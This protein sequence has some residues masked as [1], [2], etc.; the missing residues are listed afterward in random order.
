MR[1]DNGLHLSDK[2]F[3]S[4]IL[5]HCYHKYMYFWWRT[6]EMKYTDLVVQEWYTTLCNIKNNP[7]KLNV[8]RKFRYMWVC[9]PIY[10]KES[11]PLYDKFTIL[12]S[13]V[14]IFPKKYEANLISILCAYVL[15]IQ[16]ARNCFKRAT[17]IRFFCSFHTIEV[18]TNSSTFCH[19]TLLCSFILSRSTSAY[20]VI[21]LDA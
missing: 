8:I 4:H 20:K 6:L 3:R 19:G 12:F 17:N 9:I 21:W 7:W 18:E 2:I 5:N 11:I 16:S 13:D 10:I 14:F 1:Y 15:K